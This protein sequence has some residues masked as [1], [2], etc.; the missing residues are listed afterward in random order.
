MA[1]YT[2][3]QIKEKVA[4]VAAK[5][6]VGSVCLF[7]SYARGDADDDS[8]IDLLMD[9]GNI[10]DLFQYGSMIYDLEQA[11]GCHVDLITDDIRDT[12]FLGRIRTDTVTIY[13][14]D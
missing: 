12:E 11:L 3:D 14:R 5:Y 7:G 1:V 9:R 6:G 13:E 4:P 10:R 8:D 2:I